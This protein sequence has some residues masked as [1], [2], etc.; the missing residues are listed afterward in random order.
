[1]MT[2]SEP[3]HYLNGGTLDHWTKST[4]SFG[5]VF[6]V[7]YFNL[8]VEVS[9]QNFIIHAASILSMIVYA[10]TLAVISESNLGDEL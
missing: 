9:F 2:L 10:T 7:V 8:L 4:V 1:M 3:L 6:M 5:I